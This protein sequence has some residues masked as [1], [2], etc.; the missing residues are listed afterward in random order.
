MRTTTNA[1]AWPEGVI[2]RY[3]TLGGATVDVTPHPRYRA[4]ATAECHGCGQ[5]AYA[6]RDLDGWAVK[7]AAVCTLPC[8]A[9]A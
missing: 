6:E 4:P 3:L 2:A 1:D 5:M 7:H 9:A 8:S